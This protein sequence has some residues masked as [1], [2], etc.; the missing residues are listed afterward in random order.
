MCELACM[1][2]Y[3]HK[4]MGLYIVQKFHIIQ[5]LPNIAFNKNNPFYSFI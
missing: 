4:S 5:I 2:S 1:I 3:K